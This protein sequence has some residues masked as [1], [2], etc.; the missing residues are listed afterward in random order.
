MQRP[1]DGPTPASSSTDTGRTATRR[2]GTGVESGGSYQAASGGRPGEALASAAKL[3]GAIFA[4]PPALSASSL[5]SMSAAVA[6]A[7]NSRPPSG[8]VRSGAGNKVVLIR[9]D[10]GRGNALAR[11]RQRLAILDSKANSILVDQM[12]KDMQDGEDEEEEQEVEVD[13]GLSGEK[14]DAEEPEKL[15]E[16]AAEAEEEATADVETVASSGVRSASGLEN[17]DQGVSHDHPSVGLDD[18]GVSHSPLGGQQAPGPG[19]CIG[20]SDHTGT[21]SNAVATTEGATPDDEAAPTDEVLALGS[22]G[23]DTD[24]DASSTI[25]LDL[26]GP[27]PACCSRSAAPA[28]VEQQPLPPPP[29]A[30]NRM[31]VS[32]ATPLLLLLEPAS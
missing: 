13:V 12:H 20:T 5:P 29:P 17:D 32:T 31:P 6:A 24:S 27:S 25:E 7:R 15:A 30:S 26:T 3:N 8:G 2:T 19:H 14:V 18:Q 4:R 11:E 21:G 28:A 9:S 10:P 22:P 16:G 1:C 23:S